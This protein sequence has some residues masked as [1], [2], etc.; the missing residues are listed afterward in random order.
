MLEAL[1][2]D[3]QAVFE[4]V[5]ASLPPVIRIAAQAALLVLSKYYALSDDCEVYRIA[6]GMYWIPDHLLILTTCSHVP[7]SKAS[8]VRMKGHT[9]QN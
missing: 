8:L 5:H 4:Q 9:G 6:M 3:L 2:H 1:E 7:K